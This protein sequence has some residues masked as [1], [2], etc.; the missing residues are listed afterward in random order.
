MTTRPTLALVFASTLAGCLAAAPAGEVTLDPADEPASGAAAEPQEGAWVTGPVDLPGGRATVTYQ[1]VNG[2]AILEGDIDLGDAVEVAA[3]AVDRAEVILGDVRWKNATIPYVIDPSTPDVQTVQTAMANWQQQSLFR[4]VQH[5]NEPDYVVFTKNTFD[6][7]CYSA[8]GRTGNQQLIQLATGCDVP[9]TM[10]EIGHAIGLFHEQTRNDRDAYVVVHPENLQP[11]SNVLAQYS[12][13]GNGIDW[14]GFDFKSIM[15]YSSY[16]F[17]INEQPTMTKKSDGS[18]WARATTLSQT[19][20]EAA[21][22]LSVPWL[23]TPID[24]QDDASGRCVT[25][26]SAYASNTTAYVWDCA[27]NWLNEKWYWF[28]VP[29]T[30]NGRL[31]NA[32]TGL[33]LA[34]QVANGGYVTMQLCANSNTLEDY[35]THSAQTYWHVFKNPASGYCLSGTSTQNGSLMTIATCSD[36]P[37]Q[38][39]YTF[40]YF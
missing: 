23:T 36:V 34:E 12:H 6:G 15:L 10:H 16:A 26:S 35:V 30:S 24:L 37:T 3:K 9:A 7:N 33:C 5:T 39:L 17:S 27:S 2:R 31:I 22:L 28:A 32:E 21:A 25:G 20:L 40:Q 29:G 8:I 14:F 38:M 18:T 11:G 13:P 1:I 19:D 4:F